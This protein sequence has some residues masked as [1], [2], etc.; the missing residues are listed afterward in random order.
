MVA[1]Q[2]RASL[3]ADRCSQQPAAIASQ[4]HMH[5]STFGA[6]QQ[7]RLVGNTKPARMHICP[8]Q[9]CGLDAQGATDL[10]TEHSLP[11]QDSMPTC[12]TYLAA[13]PSSGCGGVNIPCARSPLA[14]KQSLV[15]ECLLCIYTRS[16]EGDHRKCLQELSL[17]STHAPWWCCCWCCCQSPQ[18]P[19]A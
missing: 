19:A 4:L 10:A 18:I 11:L 8:S 13:T 6:P 14:F 1:W 7:Y 2:L 15:R 17:W 9:Y 16:Q 3:P 12:I 5:V